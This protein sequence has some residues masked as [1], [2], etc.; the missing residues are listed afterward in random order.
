[1]FW[2]KLSAGK[3]TNTLS[4]VQLMQRIRELPDG[5]RLRLNQAGD[6][7]GNGVRLNETAL[8]LLAGNAQHLRAW[9]MTH[10]PMRTGDGHHG[11]TGRAASWNRRAVRNAA[12]Q[13]LTVNVSANGIREVDANIDAG[14]PTCVVVPSDHTVKVVRTRKGRRVITCPGARGET[15]CEQCGGAKGPLCWRAD[16]D[17]AIAFPA[18]GKGAAKADKVVS[19]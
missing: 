11:I 17:Y 16:R 8:R 9:T 4:L 19:K 14:L 6:L 18:H 2:R 3:A 7:P 12:K 13:G 15:T 10:Y 1:M 5:S